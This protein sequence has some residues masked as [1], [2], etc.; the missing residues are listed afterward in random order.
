[1]QGV[2]RDTADYMGMLATVINGLALE[3]SLGRM[4]VQACALSAIPMGEVVEAYAIR[5]ARYH[6]EQGKMVI[7]TGGTGKPYFSTDTAAALRAAELDAEV[8]L[9]ATKV[10]GVYDA[11]PV[12][13]PAAQHFPCISYQE[14]ISK[15][16]GV[17]DTT[18]VVLCMENK[19]PIIVFNMT[20]KG[21]L[22]RVLLGEKLGSIVKEA[23]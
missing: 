21:N 19:L 4:G 23:C 5:R 8:L 18:A 2:E 9:K 11:D 1:V 12:E 10:N 17:M 20:E 15:R 22:L 6:L 3:E 16:L 7:L 13:N 14:M